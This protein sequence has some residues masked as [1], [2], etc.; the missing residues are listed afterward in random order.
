MR[1]TDFQ[2]DF[3]PEDFTNQHEHIASAA[4]ELV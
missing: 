2:K 4:E 1:N 3:T